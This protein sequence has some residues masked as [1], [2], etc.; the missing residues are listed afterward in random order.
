MKQCDFLHLFRRGA[1]IFAVGSLDESDPIFYTQNQKR[2]GKC[3]MKRIV[4]LVVV[5]LLIAALVVAAYFSGGVM[6]G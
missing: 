6:K 3:V 5:L 4:S 1:G 2:K